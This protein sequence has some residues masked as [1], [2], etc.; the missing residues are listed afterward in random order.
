M[1]LITTTEELQK[2]CAGLENEEFITIDTEFLREK[3]YFPKLCL[4]QIGD[5]DKNAAAIDPLAEGLDL[6]ALYALLDNEKILKV[7]HAGR[8]DL[9]IFYHATG[10]VVHPIFDT[11]I[12]AMVC[13]FGDSIGYDKIVRH[14]SSAQI[15][16]SS[17]F[18]D[19][20]LRPLSD[21]QIDYALGDVT[22]LVDVYNFLRDKLKDTKRCN[23]L[24]QEKAV[25]EDPQTYNV[26]PKN[27]WERIKVRSAKPKML[28]ILREVAAWREERAQKRDIPK[29]WIMRDETLVDMAHQAPQ[30]KKQLAKIRN[31]GKDILDGKGADILLEAIQTGANAPKETWPKVKKK[32]PPPPHVIATIDVLKML[33]KLQSVEHE[34]AP[35]IIASGSDLEEIAKSDTADVPALKGWRMEVF[36]QAALDLKHGRLAIGLK[37][38]KITKYPVEHL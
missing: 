29:N 1:P 4:I 28:S 2:F 24:L 30:N 9:E 11:Q 16:K 14:V 31:L 22:H 7:F 37:D 23:W 10:K 3:T 38:G 17:Q 18:T 12:A 21:K 34:V 26:D 19:W 13:G 15:D 20:S 25:L 8:Q 6:S 36:G 5:K 33:L 27:A 35:K 32:E